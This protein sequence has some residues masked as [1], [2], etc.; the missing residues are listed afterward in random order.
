MPQP[1]DPPD[2]GPP[3]HS[4]PPDPAVPGLARPASAGLPGSGDRSGQ[5]GADGGPSRTER[6][7]GE[8]RADRARRVADVLRQQILAGGYDGARLPDEAALARD[9]TASRN[10][11]RDALALLAAEGL[12][13]R[14]RGIGTVVVG[15]RHPHPLD[16]LT[17]LAETLGAAG[18]VRNEVRVAEVVTAPAA[19]A[20]R[21][22]RTVVHLERVRHLAGSPLSLDNSYLAVDVGRRLLGADLAGRDVFGLIEEA[23]GQPLGAA[24]VTVAPAVADANTAALLAVPT[25]APLFAI[26]RLSR[27]AD[28]R[29][30]DLE[31]LR[32]RGDRMTL[33]ATLHR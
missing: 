14:R 23:T 29:P 27:L 2:A 11:V 3:E 28:G 5:D 26:E 17:G 19:V 21:L 4:G 30:V 31:Y 10:T 32:V 1:A 12:V 15:H 13:Q 20:A 24:D 8:R 25:G 6:P 18:E 9:F 16:R 7:A 22:G 33:S